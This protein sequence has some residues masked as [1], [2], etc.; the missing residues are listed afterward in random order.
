MNNI[1]KTLFF[2]VLSFAL[3]SCKKETENLSCLSFAKTSV[4]KVEGT[5]TASVNEEVTLTVSFMVVDGC[6]DFG[7]LEEVSAGYVTALTITAKYQGC[8]CTQAIETRKITYK[9]KKSQPGTYDVNFF[10][11]EDK[12]LT[13]R[14]TVQ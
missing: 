12:Y 5:K 10:Q 11:A 1:K 2:T 14:I 9:F 8:I 7:S 6:G 13:Y 4:I 3:L